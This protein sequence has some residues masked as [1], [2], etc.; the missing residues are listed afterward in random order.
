MSEGTAKGS[1]KTLHMVLKEDGCGVGTPE[2]G[3]FQTFTSQSTYSLLQM[4][5]GRK[6]VWNR[7]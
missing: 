7:F 5:Q 3:A 1:A 4:H 2:D 6:C